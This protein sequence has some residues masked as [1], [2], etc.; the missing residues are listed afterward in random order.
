MKQKKE[1]M[2]SIT[3]LLSLRVTVSTDNNNSKINSKPI[4]D[5]FYLHT[6]NEYVS[7]KNDCV[8]WHSFCFLFFFGGFKVTKI[9]SK[10]KWMNRV[11]RQ[12]HS[13]KF[14]GYHKNV[15]T[16]KK[17]IQYFSTYDKVIAVKV[18]SEFN[19]T[20][21]D[22]FCFCFHLIAILIGLVDGCVHVF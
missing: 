13:Q 3:S 16:P 17:F 14:C 7:V 18:Y 2:F 21:V 22:S 15:M 12:P 6:C 9:K 8:T 10:A 19:M 1:F 20:F 4:H 5:H 11:T